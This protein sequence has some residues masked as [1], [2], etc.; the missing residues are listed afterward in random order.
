MADFIL[1]IG[2]EEMPAH[3]VTSSEKQLVD[4]VSDFL[5]DHRLGYKEI[6]PFSTP[7]RL[8]V[9]LTDLAAG[10]EAVQDEK[11]GP[12]IDRAKDDNG[13]WSKAAQG[14]ARGQKTTP[15]QLVEKDGYLWAKTEIK[16]VSA[17]E[18][19]T[20]LGEEVV[21]KMTFSTY[22][23]W[24]NHSFSYIRPIRW[25]VALLDQEVVDFTVL[26]VKTGNTT[27][28]HR[29]L[30]TENV[31]VTAASNYEKDL[32]AAF[33]VVD[34]T[35]RKA[36][37]TKQLEQI[38][39]DQKWHL[40]LTTDQ[41]ED[42][43][44]EVNNIVEWPTAFAGNFDK[45]YLDLPKEVLITSMRDHQ[46]FFFVTDDEGEL[47]P[48][49]FSVRNGNE[50]NLANV[51]AGNEKVLVARLEDAVFFYQEDQQKSIDDYMERVKKLVFHEKIGTVYEHMMRVRGLAGQLGQALGLSYEEL[52]DLNRATEIYKFDLMTG[53]VG[54][55]DELQGVMGEHYA[56]LFGENDVVAHAIL[57]HYLPT[58]ATGAVADSKIG[59]V[60]AIADKL[61]SI[62][63]FFAADLIPSG[64]ND[65]YG[66]RRAAT[67]VVRTLE[68]HDWHL[69]LLDILANFSKQNKEVADTDL[70]Q[71][72]N[73]LTDRVRKLA[74]DSGVRSDIVTAGTANVVTGDLVYVADRTNVLA[75]HAKDTNFRDVMEALSRVTRLASK[76]KVEAPVKPNLLENDQEKALYEASKD[77][78]LANLEAEGAEALYQALAALQ[79]PIA[80]YFDNTLVND[81]KKAV[82]NNRYAQ[83]NALS[84]LING[85]GDIEQ[86][87]IK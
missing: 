52:S 7:R 24:G 25:L 64:A 27:R 33:V 23:K 8:A 58:S 30:S 55:F 60:L 21:E 78:D 84:T 57:E 18:I 77:L 87:V 80:A 61:D 5:A 29:F 17:A 6:K 73:F 11:R 66:L 51:V 3:L 83:L 37:I 31:Q 15:E 50:E 71:I 48:H 26:D 20:K 85:L 28:G 47:L 10:S 42:L 40:D 65:P 32:E 38:A 45:K 39:K 53:M 49:F 2:L 35:K 4:R 36:T 54:E 44:E 62:V 1:E 72:I 82:K 70:A 22:M 43:L 34:A 9:Q 67:G 79:A 56:K 68:A 16:G 69:N 63:T 19:L 12:A 59:A 81:P 13:E 46:R 75:K 76:E 14:F 74:A 41:A 86:I